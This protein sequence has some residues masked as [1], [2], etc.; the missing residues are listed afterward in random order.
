MKGVEQPP[1]FHPEGDVWTHTLLMLDGM[2]DLTATLAF[3]VLL[4]DVGKPATFRREDRIRFN[5]HA[6]LGARM[7]VDVLGRLRCSNE[8]IDRVE[9]LVAGHL[10]FAD[11]GRMRESTLKRFLRQPH[12]D[13]H[14]EL[15]RL[16]CLASHGKLDHYEF[17]RAKLTEL[18]VEQ[19]KPPRLVNGHDLIHAGYTP[20][21]PFQRML[22]LVEDAQLESRIH[23][24][25]EAIALVL[26]VFDPPDVHPKP[27]CT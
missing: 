6:E 19:L 18:P 2:R 11:V 21:P 12:F 16:D 13:E 24:K 4:H 23:T 14:L 15:H 20:G 3:G 8:E 22:D 17:L 25:D 5:G 10:R 9:A 7:A 27:A 1:E 26:S